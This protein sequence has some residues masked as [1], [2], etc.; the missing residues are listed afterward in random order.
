MLSIDAS[1]VRILIAY[2][3]IA[4]ML[5][6]L[7]MTVQECLDEY[8]ALMEQVFGSGW[9]NDYGGKQVRYIATGDFHSAAKFEEVTKGLL[10]RRLRVEKPEDALL[11]D[12]KD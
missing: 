5:G 6:R 8:S 10:R 4:L 2:R 1:Y 9:L 3:L 12:E 11:L 7:K